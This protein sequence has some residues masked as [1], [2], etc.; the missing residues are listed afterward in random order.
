[1]LSII[2][3]IC[4]ICINHDASLRVLSIYH[5]SGLVSTYAPKDIYLVKNIPRLAKGCEKVET[6]CE[7]LDKINEDLG[8]SETYLNIRNNNLL[9]C[10]IERIC[11]IILH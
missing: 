2:V 11:S 6:E 7:S 4:C 8:F 3:N 5:M 9:H 1:M 10:F